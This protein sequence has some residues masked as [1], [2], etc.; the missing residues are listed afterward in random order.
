MRIVKLIVS[1]Y[2]LFDK[3][4]LTSENNSADDNVKK[5]DGNSLY[6]RINGRFGGT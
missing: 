5:E 4:P 2:L 3:S 6:L 1:Y